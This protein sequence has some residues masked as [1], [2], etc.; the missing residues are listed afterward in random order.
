MN[1]GKKFES[2]FKDC[3]QKLDDTYCLRLYDTMNGFN[4]I[5]NPCDYI[6]FRRN[7]LYLCELKSTQNNVLN[8]ENNIRNVQWDGL[9]EASKIQGVKCYI[10]CWFTEKQITKACDITELIKHKSEGHKSISYATNIGITIPAKVKRV[11]CE[12]DFNPLLLYS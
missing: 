7:I 5:A 12:Y 2:I 9:S 1:R 10:I 4:G 8:F 11:Y 6:V 3:V